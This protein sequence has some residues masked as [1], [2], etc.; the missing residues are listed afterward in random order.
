[1]R[2]RCTYAPGFTLVELV[3]SIVIMAIIMTGLAS[4]MV[5]A[6]HAIPDNDDP[7]DAMVDAADLADEIA[8]DLRY[9][10]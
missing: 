3:A 6:T 5:L 10:A 7:L 4:A 1:M 9:R 2:H 8:A